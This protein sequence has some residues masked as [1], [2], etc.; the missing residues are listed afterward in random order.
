MWL[1]IFGSPSL[2]FYWLYS[3]I[4]LS[5][6]IT[7][8]KRKGRR[9]GGMGA[10]GVLTGI[11][12]KRGNLNT[13]TH[14]RIKTWEDESRNQ[15]MFLQ[16]KGHWRLPASHQKPGERHGTR[17]LPPTLLTPWSQT[18]SLQTVWQ[19]ISVVVATQSVAFYSGSPSRL[20]GEGNGNPLWS[21]KS[22]GRKSLAGHKV[23]KI[24]TQLRYFTFTFQAD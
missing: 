3:K 11:L 4:I 21:G 18:S 17:S 19:Y 2:L 22:H 16:T 23:A 5:K 7:K 9:R 13:D 15:M 20:I 1:L 8:T 24:W 14:T 10:K 12:T 6:Y